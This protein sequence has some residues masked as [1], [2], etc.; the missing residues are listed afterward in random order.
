MRIEN[1]DR[2][3][4]NRIAVILHSEI[5]GVEVGEE[6]DKGPVKG[7]TKLEESKEHHRQQL[8]HIKNHIKIHI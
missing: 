8:Y 6:V 1:G 7:Y 5:E 2:G 3:K 4:S